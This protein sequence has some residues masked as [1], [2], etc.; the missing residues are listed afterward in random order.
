VAI[1]SNEIERLNEILHKYSKEVVPA[2]EE[3][4]RNLAL[5]SDEQRRRLAE[6]IEASKA[7]Q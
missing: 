5:E 7:G 2:L 4:N 3:K 1:L 6:L